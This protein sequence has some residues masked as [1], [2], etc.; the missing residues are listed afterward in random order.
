MRS[1]IDLSRR[2]ALKYA[3]SCLVMDGSAIRVEGERK[4]SSRNAAGKPFGHVR[5]R[6]SCVCGPIEQR[7]DPNRVDAGIA[8]ND[9]QNKAG[10]L[11]ADLHDQHDTLCSSFNRVPPKGAHL[12]RLPLWRVIDQS[13]RRLVGIQQGDEFLVGI[14]HHRACPYLGVTHGRGLLFWRPQS[15]CHRACTWSSP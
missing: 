5:R 13:I 1:A 7:L 14:R 12:V 2:A 10:C 6:K 11:P 8:G 15:P 9:S 4:N 3:S